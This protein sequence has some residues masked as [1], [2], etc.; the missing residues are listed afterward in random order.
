MTI[1]IVSGCGIT[2]RLR[3]AQ[4]LAVHHMYSTS[5]CARQGVQLWGVIMLVWASHGPVNEPTMTH[6]LSLSRLAPE[7][8]STVPCNMCLCDCRSE[9]LGFTMHTI[10]QSPSNMSTSNHGIEF[11]NICEV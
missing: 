6:Q 10:T 3:V 5:R 8:T 4:G 7:G 11:E 2:P 9:G 1:E